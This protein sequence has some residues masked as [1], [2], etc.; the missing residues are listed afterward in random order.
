MPPQTFSVYGFPS[1]LFLLFSLQ[2]LL[3]LLNKPTS[4]FYN[5]SQRISL[6]GLQ[7]NH[8]FKGTENSCIVMPLTW[9]RVKFI[10]L[11]LNFYFCTVLCLVAQLCPTLW[12]PMDCSPP[13]S[14]VCGILQARTLEWV[15]MLSSRGSSQPRDRTQVSHVVGRFFTIEPPGKPKNTGAGSLSLLQGIFLTQELNGGL[16]H[17]RWILYQLSY[18]GSKVL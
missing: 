16:L 5:F 6:W 13:G 15:A 11:F 3:S 18:E 1:H 7:S 14:S 10:C 12:D 9:Y 17:C 2:I 4:L 8:Y